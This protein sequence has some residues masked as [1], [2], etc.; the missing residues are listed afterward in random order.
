MQY[1][2]NLADISQEMSAIFALDEWQDLEARKAFANESN[3]FLLGA[4]ACLSSNVTRRPSVGIV[5]LHSGRRNRIWTCLGLC[6]SPRR[7]VTSVLLRLPDP[8][9]TIELS[10]RTRRK[11]P[12]ATL[13]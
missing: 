3:A 11:A 8:T 13:S 6:P 4:D 9:S 2:G 10:H 1:E 5:A 7:Q 12:W